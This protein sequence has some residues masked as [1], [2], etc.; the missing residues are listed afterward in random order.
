ME[1]YYNIIIPDKE[2]KYETFKRQYNFNEDLNIDFFC[3]IFDTDNTTMKEWIKQIKTENKMTDKQKQRKQT[4]VYSG[5][6]AYFPDAINEVARCSMAGQIKHNPH[7]PLAWDRSKS[8][9]ELDA[10]TRHLMEAGTMDTDGVR[11]ST[12]IAWRAM[13]NLQKEMENENK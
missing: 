8:G 11:H 12:K 4:P 3:E 1:D 5:F 9:D 7:L 13:A 10:L 6:L 2:D